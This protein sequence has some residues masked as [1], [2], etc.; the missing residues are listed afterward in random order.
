MKPSTL[1]YDLAAQLGQKNLAHRLGMDES[2]VSRVKQG[3][4]GMKLQT[5][6]K[7]FEIGETIVLRQG[8]YAQHHFEHMTWQRKLEDAIGTLSELWNRDRIRNTR[9][10]D[11]GNAS[12]KLGKA[13]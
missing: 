6:D 5:L 1:F 3:T 13:K 10:E 8:E 4:T 11:P 7:L 9:V 2:E 12:G